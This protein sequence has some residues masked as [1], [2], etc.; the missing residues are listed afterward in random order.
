MIDFPI[1]DT[2]LHLWDPGR[3]RYPWLDEFA[4]LNKPH[5][6]DD[7]NVSC[8]QYTIDKMVFVQCEA[9]PSQ[10]MEEVEFVTQQAKLDTRIGALVAWA[11]LEKGD[12]VRPELDVLKENPL[13]RGIRRIIQFEPDPAWCLQD[14]YIKGVRALADYDLTFDICIKGPEQTASALELVRR[15]P[16]VKFIVDHIAKPYIVDHQME[17]W[18]MHIKAFARLGNVWCKMSGLVVEADHA[19][20][21]TGDLEPYIHHVLDCF[22]YDRVMFG[23]DW[24]VVLLASPLWKWIAALDHATA[25]ADADQRVKLFRDNARVFYRLT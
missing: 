22:G 11:P 15:C 19:H 12:A 7:Y 23:G 21:T 6:L 1:I 3:I 18:A 17:P 9:H 10:Y 5:L 14:D 20:W 2:H 16:E 25:T 8:G 4:K 13:L 24:P